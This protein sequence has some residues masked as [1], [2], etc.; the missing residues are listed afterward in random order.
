MPANRAIR[1]HPRF[2]GLDN[3]LGVVYEAA[4]KYILERSAHTMRDLA[5]FI[6]FNMEAD[7]KFTGL[8]I[9]RP[10]VLLDKIMRVQPSGGTRFSTA[11]Q[12][13]WN[14]V[15]EVRSPGGSLT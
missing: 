15:N 2:Q 3:V 1:R 5:T 7:V 10:A 9:S 12:K 4:Y 14:A 11:L 13:M 8:S 6:P